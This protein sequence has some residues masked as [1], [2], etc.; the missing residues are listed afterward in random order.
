MIDKYNQIRKAQLLLQREIIYELL[1][2]ETDDLRKY[3]F[4]LDL[5]GIEAE[6][7]MIDMVNDQYTSDRL[8]E[9]GGFWG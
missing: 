6:I 1:K 3:Y 9:Q 4:R 2:T 8:V 7:Y 5:Q